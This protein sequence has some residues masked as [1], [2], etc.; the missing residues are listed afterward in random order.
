MD[1]MALHCSIKS[2]AGLGMQ[3]PEPFQSVGVL[4][5]VDSDSRAHGHSELN[6]HSRPVDVAGKRL[7]ATSPV[8]DRKALDAQCAPGGE[9]SLEVAIVFARVAPRN[10][11][12]SVVPDPFL[13]RL[14]DCEALVS[15]REHR[16]EPFGHVI[17]DELNEL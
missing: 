9:H 6:E 15:W 7:L 2:G 5:V 12:E 17:S 13:E 3:L 10:C 8:D 11:S 4:L 1:N 16:L 14:P